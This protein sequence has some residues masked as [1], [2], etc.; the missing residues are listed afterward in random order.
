MHNPPPPPPPEK[1]YHPLARLLRGGL[2]LASHLGMLA[3]MLIG[4]WGIERLMKSL[5]GGK[6]LFFDKWPLDYILDGSDLVLLA[7]FL[8]IG[9]YVVLRAY[10]GKRG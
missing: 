8:T 6:R 7:V 2:E 4:I 9:I 1:W 3:L 5:W 10:Y